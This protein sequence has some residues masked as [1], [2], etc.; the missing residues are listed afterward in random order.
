MKKTLLHLSSKVLLWIGLWMMGLYSRFQ[1]WKISCNL[2]MDS[3]LCELSEVRKINTLLHWSGD[4]GIKKLKS[5][6]KEPKPAYAQLHL[7]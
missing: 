3:E 6:Q 4:F 1:T 7:G 5:W 2:I